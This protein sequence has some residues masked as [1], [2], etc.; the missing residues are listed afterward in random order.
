[1][2][3]PIPRTPTCRLN[4]TAKPHGVG[5]RRPWWPSGI[6]SSSSSP[7]CCSSRSRTK[8]S[9]ATTSTSA[10]ARTPRNGSCADWRSSGIRSPCNQITPPLEQYFSEE[11]TRPCRRQPASSVKKRLFKEEPLSCYYRH[12][13]FLENIL[14]ICQKGGRHACIQEQ[15][16]HIVPGRFNTRVRV[17]HHS[18]AGGISP[19]FTV[20]CCE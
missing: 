11:L 4:T 14:P 18:R 15:A 13:P 9:E 1:M 3:Q 19:A 7:R 6:P 10:S 20:S 8:S 2:P 17:K 12:R 5:R 16:Y